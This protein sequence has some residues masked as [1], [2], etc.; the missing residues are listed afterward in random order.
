METIDVLP[1]ALAAVAGGFISHAKKKG[2]LEGA[3]LGGG[4]AVAAL[5]VLECFDPKGRGSWR[6]GQLPQSYSPTGQPG[7]LVYNLDPRRDPL[8]D[9]VSRQR[10]YP[11]WLLLHWQSGDPKIISQLQG[12]LGVAADGAIGGATTAAL[13]AFQSHAG[14][15]TTG[16]MDRAT[17]EALIAG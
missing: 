4:S 9:P 8:L 10:L 1:V 7:Q 3:L 12:F 2:I 5:V 13:R 11:D 14:L 16:V 6:V 15:P 17:M